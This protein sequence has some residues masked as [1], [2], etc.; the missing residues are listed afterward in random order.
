[1]TERWLH[2]R[3][4]PE[5]DRKAAGLG[6]AAGLLVGSVVFYLA[7]HLLAREWIPSAAELEVGKDGGG[8]ASG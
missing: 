1:M 5:D 8:G 2:R 7:R 4:R 6:L 3:P